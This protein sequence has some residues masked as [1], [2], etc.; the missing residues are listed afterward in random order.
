[1]QLYKVYRTIRRYLEDMN[2][3]ILKDSKLSKYKIGI[4]S[5]AYRYHIGTDSFQPGIPMKTTDFMLK[6]HQLGYN[7][8]QLCENLMIV[9]ATN[10]E[11][12]HIK[13]K[14]EEYG[15]IIEVGMN[16]LEQESLKRHIEICNLLSARF[17]RIVLGGGSP[18][19]RN[20]L[21]EAAGKAIEVLS[22]NIEEIKKSEITVGIENHF[23]FPTAAIVDIVKA[24]NEPS[25]G[26]I[27]DTTNC[28]GFIEKPEEMLCLAGPHLLSVHI[29]DYIVKKVEG[30]YFITGQILGKGF[31]DAYSFLKT[32]FS[33]NPHVSIILEMTIKKEDTEKEKVLYM[34]NNAVEQSTN[35][36]FTLLETII[37]TE[38]GV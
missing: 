34:E 36:L 11:L 20:D 21:N 38:K 10:D 8:V 30:G 17:L 6:A 35:Y 16:G 31:L 32:A 15:L 22:K 5:Y 13:H 12:L 27:A 19:C 33:Y 25:I 23:D 18:I 14:A 7:L 3:N 29:K 4:G 1:M 37:Q 28:L 2:L 24:I 26:I 9:N